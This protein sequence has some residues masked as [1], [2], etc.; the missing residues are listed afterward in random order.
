MVHV[1]HH[2]N[3]RSPR[4]LI[5]RP[6]FLDLLF[7]NDL[8]FEAHHLHDSVERL[9][10][11]RR[12]GRVQRLIDAGENAAVKQRLQQFLGANVEL[13]GQLPNRDSF[14][15]RYFARLALYW[16]HR[17]G[18]RRSSCACTRARSHRMEFALAFRIAL[19]D[20]RTATRC[21]WLP[22]IQRL[23]GF[24]LR[25]SCSAGCTGTLSAHRSLP[26]SATSFAGAA[27]TLRISS[28][29]SASGTQWHTRTRAD[30]AS[31]TGCGCRT[32]TLRRTGT[33]LSTWWRSGA[34]WKS[35]ALRRRARGSRCSRTCS[36][37]RRYSRWCRGGRALCS[38]SAR[39]AG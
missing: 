2:R 9:S 28:C 6:D 38:R 15:D 13:L 39:L 12:R 14:G 21:R 3:H 33:R 22:R 5:A 35:L 19:L 1:S 27:R 11:T 16:R 37:R 26:G 23:A 32:K 8:L 30:G 36:R 31:L 17:L 29:R 20:E 24:S 4:L 34:N 7:L 18:L 25:N 10:E